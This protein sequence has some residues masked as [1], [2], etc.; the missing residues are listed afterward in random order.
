VTLRILCTVLASVAFL[1]ACGGS[2]DGSSATPGSG[3]ES[4]SAGSG[5]SGGAAGAPASGGASGGRSASGCGSAVSPQAGQRSVDVGGTERTYYLH[6]PTGYDASKAWPLVFNFHGRTASTFG[7]AAPLQENVSLLYEKGDAAGFIVVNPQGLTDSDGTQ[8]WNAGLCCAEDKSR[9]DV[10]FVD[11]MLASLESELCVDA[12]RIYATGLS[13]GGFMSHRLAC[14]RADRFAAVAPVAAM[15]GMTTC[16]PSRPPSVIAFNGTA[17]PLVDYGLAKTS[18]TAWV[19][20]NGCNATPTETFNNGDSHCDTYSGCT[21]GAE[22]VLCTVEDGG[23]TWPGG[24][25]LSALGFGKTTQDLIANDAMW[26]FFE[27]HPL[28]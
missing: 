17:D 19:T 23:H 4:G 10:A 13:N 5:G 16:S 11:A 7:A 22:V 15:N 12:K 14:E 21:D 2:D 6:V 27:K 3:G 25:D 8:T 9:D 1:T 28:P 20:R 24:M 18:I 26:D